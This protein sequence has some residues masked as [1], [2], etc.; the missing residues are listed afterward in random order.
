MRKVLRAA[1]NPSGQHGSGQ[2]CNRKKKP[3]FVLVMPSSTLGTPEILALV[4]EYLPR[5]QLRACK[6]TSR[7][8]LKCAQKVEELRMRNVVRLSSGQIE[9]PLDSCRYGGFDILDGTSGRVMVYRPEANRGLEIDFPQQTFRIGSPILEIQ[10]N[11]TKT[12]VIHCL[13]RYL[14]CETLTMEVALS[15]PDPAW[16]KD[17]IKLTVTAIYKPLSLEYR[18]HPMVSRLCDGLHWHGHRNAA[19]AML[20]Y[21]TT[22]NIE[23][24]MNVLLD[25]LQD[26]LLECNRAIEMERKRLDILT[27]M[28]HE[29]QAKLLLATLF[30]K[31]DHAFLKMITSLN[32]FVT[33][34]AYKPADELPRLIRQ[35]FLAKVE[36][37]YSPTRQKQARV[38]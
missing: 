33:D 37:V 27:R 1:I 24:L 8:W 15:P 32:L 16:T 19:S 9:G 7:L 35:A 17:T 28:K 4:F 25:V 36:P 6:A 14:I 18:I 30:A 5:D 38:N 20:L 12:P 11:G 31:V 23:Y 2:I 34:L 10:V 22:T 29:T 3:R 26:S 13:D 21:L